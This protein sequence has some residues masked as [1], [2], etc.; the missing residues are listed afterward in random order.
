MRTITWSD[1]KVNA[2]DAGSMSGL[3]YLLRVKGGKIPPPPAAILLGYRIVEVDPGLAVF[4]LEPAEYLCNPFGTVHGG[5]ASTL[6]DTAMTASVL[7]T[8][9]KGLACSTLEIKVNFISPITTET[10]LLR[11]EAK[12]VHVGKRVATAEGKILDQEEKLYAVGMSTC[13]VFPVK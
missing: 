7:S 11:C 9:P 13:M 8:L 4:E 12:T 1:P 2:R 10:G 3:D 6:L 5:I